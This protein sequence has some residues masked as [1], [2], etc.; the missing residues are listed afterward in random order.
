MIVPKRFTSGS[1]KKMYS[2][3]VN[4]FGGVFEKNT[5]PYF[6]KTDFNSLTKSVVLDATSSIEEGSSSLIFIILF[7]YLLY[8]VKVEK[9]NL[10]M[11]K[12]ISLKQIAKLKLLT[13]GKR[14]VVVGGCFDIFHYGHLFFLK[15]A[16]REGEFLIVFLESDEFIKQKKKRM[17]VHNQK[18]RA[19]LLETLTIVDM[20]ILLPFFTK[21]NEYLNLVKQV[22]PD[23]IAV[24]RGDKKIGLKEK[25]ARAIN[26]I[27]KEVCPLLTKFSSRRLINNANFSRN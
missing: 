26:G 2:N 4:I 25:Q 23:V 1:I 24:T 9:D 10:F 19:E 27:V 16:K 12:I 18:Q 6:S 3:W 5:R 8:N 14:T 21:D 20:V 17:S 15:S 13:L 7:I 22:K 11:S